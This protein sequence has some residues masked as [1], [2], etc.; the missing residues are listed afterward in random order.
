MRALK[1]NKRQFTRTT[2]DKK[3]PITSREFWI[4]TTIKVLKIFFRLWSIF[5]PNLRYCQERTKNRRHLFYSMQWLWSV[6]S[7]SDRLNVNLVNVWKSIKNA[8]SFAKRKFS[9]V[10]VPI[11][12]NT[13]R[14][15]NFKI[16][17]W[18]MFTV[19]TIVWKPGISTPPT[20]LQIV[21][22]AAYYLTPI[23]PSS[24]KRVAY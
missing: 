18:S 4:A 20:L 5:L 11:P 2:V 6:T 12:N 13:I 1:P 9:F 14:W 16:N 22:M 8:V 19:S 3:G 23:D 17:T 24:E 10:R 7:I 15:D 21:M